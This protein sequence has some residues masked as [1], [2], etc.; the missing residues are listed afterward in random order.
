MIRDQLLST[1]GSLPKGLP[2]D[3]IVSLLGNK[4]E[5]A[6]FVIESLLMLSPEVVI[7]D[8]SWIL[9]KKGRTSAILS[10]IEAYAD[11]TGKKIFRASAALA[12]LPP[13]AQPTEDE[14]LSALSA[15]H[16]S[17]EL[18]PNLMIKRRS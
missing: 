7:Q 5:L 1:L 10:A 8:D 15:S 11:S 13:D 17:F 6:W 3:H 14:L 2:L 16:G 4:D 18:L 9:L 12:N